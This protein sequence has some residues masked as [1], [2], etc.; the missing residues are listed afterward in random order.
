MKKKLQL[1]SSE[2]NFFPSHN[3]FGFSK[4]VIAKAKK[5]CLE[6]TQL[7]SNINTGHTLDA[8]KLKSSLDPAIL[9]THRVGEAKARK[10]GGDFFFDFKFLFNNFMQLSGKKRNVPA[11]D[12]ILFRYSIVVVDTFMSP[13]LISLQSF[14]CGFRR[15]FGVS[16]RLTL[17]I[18][19]LV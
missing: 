12:K 5:V 13:L 2:V 9:L 3:A 19:V 16:R 4:L 18:R 17:W 15:G 6:S 1:Q 7:I 14:S 10:A 11:D 8:T